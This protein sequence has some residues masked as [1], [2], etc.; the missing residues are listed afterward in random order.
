MLLSHCI[1]LLTSTDAIMRKDV[2]LWLGVETLEQGEGL[3]VLYFMGFS[4]SWILSLGHPVLQLTVVKAPLPV[5]WAVW[6]CELIIRDTA[7]EDG[8][9]LCGLV[10]S[11]CNCFFSCYTL[12]E[13]IDFQ[14]DGTSLVLQFVFCSAG[15]QKGKM[16]CV[17]YQANH[18]FLLYSSVVS[19]FLQLPIAQQKLKGT[20]LC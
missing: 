1:G 15:I 7:G 9:P 11:S 16:N 8:V 19:V 10:Q 18:V 17:V 14:L 20:S 6:F 2:G 12:L 5:S 3:E 4:R 13:R